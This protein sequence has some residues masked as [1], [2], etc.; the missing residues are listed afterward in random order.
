LYPEWSKA[1]IQIQSLSLWRLVNALDSP[2]K[3]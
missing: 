2:F 1:E 3:T